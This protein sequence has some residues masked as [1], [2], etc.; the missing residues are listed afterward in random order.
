MF[1]RRCKEA[2]YKTKTDKIF[3][4]KFLG[5]KMYLD[6]ASILRMIITLLNVIYVN[7]H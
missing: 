4:Q 3:L 2:K 6:D 1:N 7:S 5:A